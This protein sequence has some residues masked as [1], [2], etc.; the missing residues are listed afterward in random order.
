MAVS[1]IIPVYDRQVEAHR[2]AASVLSQQGVELELIMVDD[3]SPAPLRLEPTLAADRRLTLLRR[4]RNGGAAAARQAGVAAAKGQWI[5]FLDSDDMWRPGKLAAQLA[6]AEAALAAG[7]PPL[8]AFVTGFRQHEG[9]T[10]RFRDR[11]PVDSTN[12]EDFASGCWFAPGSTALVHRVA[13]DAA[14]PFDDRLR[15]LEDLDWFFRLALAGGGVRTIE[16]IWADIH[17]AR[18]FVQ[19]NLDAAVALLRRK[20]LD[21]DSASKLPASTRDAMS[22][23]LWLELASSHMYAGRRL[24]FLSAIGRSLHFRPRLRMPL[25][26]WWR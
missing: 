5:A 16:G 4:E 12:A 8:T 18:G 9:K 1:V 3:A 26:D 20:W 10:G 19:A 2:A 21:D 23:Y 14:G 13:F 6:F 25:R 7:A 24:P 15:R 22:A 17:V 11:V